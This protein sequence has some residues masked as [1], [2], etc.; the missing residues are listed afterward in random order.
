MF[1]RKADFTHSFAFPVSKRLFLLLGIVI[2]LIPISACA[3]SAETALKSCS[4]FKDFTISQVAD[5]QILESRD[6]SSL[7]PQIEAGQTCFIIKASPDAVAARI[8]SW[9]PAGK[10]GL[11]VSKHQA[12]PSSAGPDAFSGT[13]AAFFKSGGESNWIATQSK[14]AKDPSC[15]LLLTAAEKSQLAAASTPSKLTTAWANILANRFNSFRDHGAP[16]FGSLRSSLKKLGVS[17]IPAPSGD[18]AYYWEVGDVDNRG[19]FSEGVSW[20]D[21]SGPRRIFDGEFFVTSEYAAS[22]NVSTLWP[23][24]IKGKPAT[25]VWRIDAAF[26]DQFTDQSAAERIASSGLILSSAKK[27]IAALRQGEK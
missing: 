23:I 20:N 21:S 3:D 14:N 9:N 19:E 16:G 11:E 26:A 4:P 13:L 27:T 6:G 5:G 15:E 24:S 2:L 8:L 18:A 10:P 17:D 22:L 12:L 25:L 7:S 1:C